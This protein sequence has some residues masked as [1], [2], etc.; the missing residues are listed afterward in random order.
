M[1]RRSIDHTTTNPNSSPPI[2]NDINN[3]PFRRLAV[4]AAIKALGPFRPRRVDVLFLTNKI[5]IKYGSLIQMSEAFTLQFIAMHTSIPVPRVHCAFVH[6]GCTYIVMERIHGETLARTWYA[7]SADSKEK[8]F[9]QLRNMV[10]EMRALPSPGPAISNV[11]GGPVYDPRFPGTSLAIGPFQSIHDFHVF[12]RNGIVEPPPDSLY[13]G[14]H[15]MMRSQDQPWPMP[16]F[17][18]GDLS[19]FNIL[20]RGDRVVGIID[21]ETAGW[22][23]SYWEY[24]MAW[25]LA[26]PRNAFWREETERFLDPPMPHELEMERTR[27]R[28]FG[29]V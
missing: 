24:S 1:Q 29:D 11:V 17:T 22:Y 20:V 15:D 6:K 2:P 25:W 19:S 4:L 10:N 28:Y 16:V 26:N 13:P 3:T 23:P 7:R 14:I 8:I 27:V 21:W 9:A 5:C 12:L 18:H